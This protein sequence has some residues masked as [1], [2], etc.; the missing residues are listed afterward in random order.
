MIPKPHLDDS[1]Q[2]SHVPPKVFPPGATCA[3]RL[4]FL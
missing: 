4:F 2:F 1:P 3:E